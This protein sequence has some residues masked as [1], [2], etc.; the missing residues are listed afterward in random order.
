MNL[1]T[2]YRM[3]F[4]AATHYYN[5]TGEDIDDAICELL[6]TGAIDYDNECEAGDFPAA[7][8]A[9]VST[10]SYVPTELDEDGEEDY[11]DGFAECISIAND[12]GYD[13]CI[14]FEAGIH[15]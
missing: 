1:Q 5:F 12:G 7:K 10:L 13:D 8:R 4:A 11:I 6:T 9:L 2:Y 15:F 14:D 3:Q